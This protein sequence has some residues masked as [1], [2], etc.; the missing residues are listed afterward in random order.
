MRLRH[1]LKVDS[2]RC[3][4]KDWKAFREE[5]RRLAP[6]AKETVDE[7]RTW[8]DVKLLTV[9]VDRLLNWY[10]TGTSVHR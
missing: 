1:T 6:F 2:N 10:R 9:R 4:D 5:I 3:V 8:E 7:L